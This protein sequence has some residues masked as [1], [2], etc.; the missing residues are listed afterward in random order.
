[1]SLT[2]SFL[3]EHGVYDVRGTVVQQSVKFI[4]QNIDYM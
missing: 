2:V 1:M 4:I 3:L